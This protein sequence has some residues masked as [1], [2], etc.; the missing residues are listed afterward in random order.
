MI[1]SS[2]D[3]FMSFDTIFWDE[4]QVNKLLIGP[5]HV[6]FSVKNPNKFSFQKN[7]SNHVIHKLRF[8]LLKNQKIRQI[9]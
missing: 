3:L 6:F 5:K 9:T 4:N 2:K 8:R 1:S 7:S